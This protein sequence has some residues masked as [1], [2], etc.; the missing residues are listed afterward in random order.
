MKNAKFLLLILLLLSGC[1]P[2]Q[3]LWKG[4]YISINTT[5]TP[6]EDF[7]ASGFTVISYAP[8]EK[9]KDTYTPYKFALVQD[10][11]QAGV[12]FLEN[13]SEFEALG[14]SYFLE[15]NGVKRSG[16]IPFISSFGKHVSYKSY[17]TLPKYEEVKNDVITILSGQ[18]P[19]EVFD[20]T[21]VRSKEDFITNDYIVIAY[22]PVELNKKT[23]TLYKFILI[24][25]NVEVGTIT[26][27]RHKEKKSGVLETEYLLETDV[28][29][30][31]RVPCISSHKDSLSPSN[32]V[33]YKS[34]SQQPDYETLKNDVISVLS[35]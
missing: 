20:T 3:V 17:K 11:K 21:T 5:E 18:S 34:Y 28:K 7:K 15:E 13:H 8:I 33:T 10:N 25:E 32:H 14:T 27:E 29:G 24:M 31:W 22:A 23:N 26:L 35:K 2:K 4:N 6:K 30:N 1:A 12:I 9:N 19:E 16:P